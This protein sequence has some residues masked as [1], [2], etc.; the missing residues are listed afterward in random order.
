MS[1]E[2]T[3]RTG[4]LQSSQLDYILV[5][6]SYSMQKRWWETLAALDGFMATLRSQNIAS[7]GIVTVFDTHTLQSIQRDSAIADWQTFSADPLG[8]TWG[9]TPLYDAINL[10]GRHLKELDPAKASI[11]I[12]TDGEE[13]DSRHTTAAQAKAILDWC[14]AKGWQVT[15]LGADFNN[16]KQAKLL[17]ASE[18][19]SIGVRKELLL[20]AGKVLGQKRANNARSGDDITFSEDEK[21]NFGGFL[22]DGSSGK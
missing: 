15:F 9:G 2:L 17:G 1:K 16:S 3:L 6:G 13:G 19:N 11:V 20:E 18:A 10:M 8:S 22:T 14:R 21:E 4:H 5:D 7:H 12:V